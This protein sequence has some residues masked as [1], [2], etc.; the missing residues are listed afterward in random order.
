MA[1]TELCPKIRWC[2][3]G[4]PYGQGP[5]PRRWG[6]AVH[7][8][9][10]LPERWSQDV[11]SRYETQRRMT[12]VFAHLHRSRSGTATILEQ[13]FREQVDRWKDETAHWSSVVK[14]R[15]HPSYLRIIGLAKLSTNN[16]IERL[17]LRELEEEPDH[18][19]DALVALTGENP[20]QPH[21]DFDEAVNAWLE[22]GRERNLLARTSDGQTHDDEWGN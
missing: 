16:E 10:R 21:H 13:V 19:F 22:W 9:R 8:K 7:G 17:L 11:K 12:A 14:M 5:D 20:V 4:E 18:W 3:W 1:T 2:Q 15:A 6:L